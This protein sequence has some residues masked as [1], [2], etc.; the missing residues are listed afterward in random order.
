MPIVSTIAISKDGLP[1]HEGRHHFPSTVSSRTS[2]NDLV[3]VHDIWIIVVTVTRIASLTPIIITVASSH[4]QIGF[5]IQLL[6]LSHL[7]LMLF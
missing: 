2:H 5:P 1:V 7:H 6:A 3:L 4:I